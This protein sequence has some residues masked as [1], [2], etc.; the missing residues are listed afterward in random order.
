MARFSEDGSSEA[1][2]KEGTEATFEASVLYAV[3]DLRQLA[4]GAPPAKA[5]VIDAMADLLAGVIAAKD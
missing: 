5:E 1:P 4:S 2:A 3:A